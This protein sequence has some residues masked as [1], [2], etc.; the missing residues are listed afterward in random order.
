MSDPKI[1]IIVP[2]YN[3]QEYLAGCLE[4][5]LAQTF[6]DFEVICVDDGSTDESGSIAEEY[7]QKESRIHVIHQKNKGLSGARN[8]GLDK[9]KGKYVAFCDSDDYYHPEFLERM[10]EALETSGADVAGCQLMPTKQ[11]YTGHFPS[12]KDKTVPVQI[13]NHPIKTFLSTDKIRTGVHIKLYRRSSLSDLKFIEGIYFED[14]PFT[15]VLMMEIKQ[16]ALINLPLYYYYK[17]PNSIMRTSFNLRKVESYVRLIRHIADYT[18]Q[19]HPD[20]QTAVRKN[21]LNKRFKMM[22]N[23]AIRK[24]KD[25]TKRHELF[26]AIQK[27]VILL[28]NQGIISYHG[29]KPRHRLTLF[30]LLHAK[31]SRP[32]ECVMKFL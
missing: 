29:L 28:F 16:F 17:N 25:V 13:F 2:V 32:A 31:T 21:I 8:T 11:K 19:H 27:E 4:S 1:S 6:Q 12:F 23:Q 26:D 20:L 3:V 5:I 7:A 10:H 14:V 30:L 22:I 18:A 9:A 24:Q 15:T